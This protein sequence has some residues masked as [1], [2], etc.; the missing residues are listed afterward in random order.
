L[1][2]RNISE[3]DSTP[4]LA[5]LPMTT[6]A[7]RVGVRQW[8]QPMQAAA[9]ITAAFLTGVVAGCSSPAI[10][11][12]GS[13][14]TLLFGTAAVGDICVVVHR[15]QGSAFQSPGFGNTDQQGA[16]HLLQTGGQEALVLEP[17]EYC[18]TLESLGPPMVFPV[19]Y[20]KP[21]TTP[22]KVNWTADMKSLDLKAPEELLARLPR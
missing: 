9:L 11:T 21:D 20:R 16:F 19:V 14:G 12:D 13:P 7:M 1:T 18:F 22:L 5:L 10:S 4:R 2:R 15:R 8:L 6:V 3:N 17:G